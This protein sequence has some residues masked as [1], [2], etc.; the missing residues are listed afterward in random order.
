VSTW[1]EVGADGGEGNPAERADEIRFVGA[2]EVLDLA[3][4]AGL[5]PETIA[6][7]YD[8]TPWSEASERIVLVARAAPA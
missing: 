1:F 5:T 7:N 6:G 8:M 4:Q 3:E 2:R